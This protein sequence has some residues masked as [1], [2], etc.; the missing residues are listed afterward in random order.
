MSVG[1]NILLASWSEVQPDVAGELKVVNNALSSQG[2]ESY[3]EPTTVPDVYTVI[4]RR[5]CFG[6]SAL[7]ATSAASLA[8]LGAAAKS[9]EVPLAALAVLYTYPVYLLPIDFREPITLRTGQ[10]LRYLCSS[11]EIQRNLLSLAPSIGITLRNG[12]LSDDAAKAINAE[13]EDDRAFDWLFLFE[14]ARLS[15]A[16]RCA[17]VIA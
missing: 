16:H 4:D 13:G 17:I 10:F 9:S 6:R 1:A 11:H 14:A 15:V 12:M 5:H 3:D 7:D 8:S 2:L